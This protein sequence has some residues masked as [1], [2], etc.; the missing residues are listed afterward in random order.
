MFASTE[1]SVFVSVTDIFNVKLK[2]KVVYCYTNINMIN[3]Q[4]SEIQMIL[5]H[6]KTLKGHFCGTFQPIE[7]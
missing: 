7:L 6:T 1:V 4:C 3:D 5:D 2:H